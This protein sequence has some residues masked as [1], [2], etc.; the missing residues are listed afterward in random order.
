MKLFPFFSQLRGA[1]GYVFMKFT[2]GVYLGI[3]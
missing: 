2:L 3:G 1:A